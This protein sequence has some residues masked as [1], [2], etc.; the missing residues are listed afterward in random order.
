MNTFDGFYATIAMKV[1]VVLCYVSLKVLLS[2]YIQRIFPHRLPEMRI[3]YII[4]SLS[5]YHGFIAGFSM[6]F[7]KLLMMRVSGFIPLI[8]FEQDCVQRSNP[9]IFQWK[10]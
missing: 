1:F 10:T 8:Q 2:I 7:C 5:G 9:F 3:S 4:C 6:Q